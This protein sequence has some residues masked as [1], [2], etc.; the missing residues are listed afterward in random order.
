MRW[1]PTSSGFS[2]A[3]ELAERRKRC[4]RISTGSKQW[5]A[6]LNGYVSLR[7]AH[8]ICADLAKRFSDYECLRG[9]WRVQ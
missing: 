4:F 5:D 7:W 1:Q 8:C 6:A 3:A 2:T 9:L